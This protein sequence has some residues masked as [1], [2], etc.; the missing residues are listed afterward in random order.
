MQLLS[1]SGLRYCPT[2][3][4]FHEAHSLRNVLVLVG[5]DEDWRLVKIGYLGRQIVFP[6]SPL[7]DNDVIRI[8]VS[9]VCC[10]L[11]LHLCASAVVMFSACS[12]VYDAKGFG[13][14]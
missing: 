6:L 8:G 12:I 9:F 14:V 2:C 1:Y 3:D 4:S 10:D 7:L 5:Q 13:Q 11:S